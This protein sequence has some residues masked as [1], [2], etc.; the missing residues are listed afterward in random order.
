MVAS[1]YSNKHKE[2][3]VVTSKEIGLEVNSE[4]TKYMVMSRD[5][6]SR[7]NH[8]MKIDNKFSERVEQFK[9]FGTV[10]T[11]QN[12]IQE[13]IKSRLMSGNVCYHSV[14]KICLKFYK[15]KTQRLRYVE[16]KLCLLFCMGV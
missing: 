9:H 5:K 6:N 15:P 14:Q 11:T 12:C 3:L 13:E 7:R 8:N 2:S 16:Q 1:L 4:T 10:L